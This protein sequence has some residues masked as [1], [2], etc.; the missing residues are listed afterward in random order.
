MHIVHV[1]ESFGGGVMTA[2]FSYAR[3]LP[4][5]DHSIVYSGRRLEFD[6]GE[7]PT[8]VFAHSVRLPDRLRG[9]FRR[10]PSAVKQI[11]PD[12]VHAH[13]SW[14]GL[15]TRVSP[16]IGRYPIVY[17]P[18]CFYFDRTD[19]RGSQRYAIRATE[20]RLA[21]RTAVMAW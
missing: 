16:T 18:H 15:G 12:V 17:S 4:E 10:L 20:K 7:D 3:S 21:Q 8:N 6:T 9:F 1:A 19:I 5:Y 11:Q 14:A 2:V 13:S